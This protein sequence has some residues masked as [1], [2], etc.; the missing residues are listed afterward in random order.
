MP[1][2]SFWACAVSCACCAANCS[3][4]KAS[5]SRPAWALS[6]TFLASARVPCT[7]NGAATAPNAAP[8]TKLSRYSLRASGSAMFRPACKRSK[9]CCPASVAPSIPAIFA[10]PAMYWPAV[11]NVPCSSIF[12]AACSVMSCPIERN[13]F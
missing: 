11:F 2:I 5:S 12:L 7:P 1:C 3:A 6:N 10:P 4:F 13:I 8:P 9:N